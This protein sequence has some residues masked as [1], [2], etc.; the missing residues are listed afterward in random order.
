MSDR[1]RA[2]LLK[3]FAENVFKRTSTDVNGNKIQ[4]MQH[5]T[6]SNDLAPWHV[7]RCLRYGSG[8]IF[9]VLSVAPR[10]NQKKA[11]GRGREKGEREYGRRTGPEHKR[12]RE[13]E[14]EW[15]AYYG[16]RNIHAGSASRSAR[17]SADWRWMKTRSALYRRKRE[18]K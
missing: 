4:C 3:N 9:S 12:A 2:E 11:R 14:G 10:K 15:R 5:E 16:E 18:R 6:L 17:P 8:R 7:S 1:Y 13:T